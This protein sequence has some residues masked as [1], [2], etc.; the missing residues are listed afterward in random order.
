MKSAATV[1][2]C[3]SEVGGVHPQKNSP[4]FAYHR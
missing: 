4:V 3:D 2:A 1:K